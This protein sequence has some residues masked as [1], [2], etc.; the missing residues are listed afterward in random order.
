[1]SPAMRTGAWLV[2]AVAAMGAPTTNHAGL[3]MRKP[4]LPLLLNAPHGPVRSKAQLHPTVAH[5]AHT[6]SVDG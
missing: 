3:F 2:A 1:M 5:I 4:P 6:P